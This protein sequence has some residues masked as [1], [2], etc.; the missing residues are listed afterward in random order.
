MQ[1]Y[2]TQFTW[3][4]SVE[5]VKK[6]SLAPCQLCRTK[7]MG[8]SVCRR[9]RVS[10]LRAPGTCGGRRQGAGCWGGWNAPVCR[11]PG[12]RVCR[13]N[14]ALSGPCCQGQPP[15]QRTAVLLAGV[16]SPSRRLPLIERRRERERER[17]QRST[18]KVGWQVRRSRKKRKNCV[19]FLPLIVD[20]SKTTSSFD[21]Q[22][23]LLARVESVGG[24]LL[25][26]VEERPPDLAVP[27]VPPSS[28]KKRLSPFTAGC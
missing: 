18:R 11:D 16:P 23:F 25:R 5:S 14:G 28:T 1:R 27:P 22:A 12:P 2:S 4:Q 9:R 7:Q 20:G 10:L 21:E 8:A 3:F 26:F 6:S 19:S 13:T 24:R 17:R 15:W